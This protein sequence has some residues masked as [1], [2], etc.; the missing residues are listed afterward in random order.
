MCDVNVDRVRER[1]SLL[2]VV[3][4]VQRKIVTFL[5]KHLQGCDLPLSSEILLP[6]PSPKLSRSDG[7][8]SLRA[9]RIFGS[10]VRR[11]MSFEQTRKQYLS[12]AGRPYLP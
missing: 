1:G 8:N 4:I 10:L 9:R 7:N 12:P 3:M 11:L 5:S 6:F 2:R